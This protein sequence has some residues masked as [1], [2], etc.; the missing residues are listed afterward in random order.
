MILTGIETWKMSNLQNKLLLCFDWSTR[1]IE[2]QQKK[3]SGM[4][5]IKAI[6]LIFQVITATIMTSTGMGCVGCYSPQ[7]FTGTYYLYHQISRRK[8]GADG[9]CEV[10]I[11]KQQTASCLSLKDGNLQIY[12]ENSL[13]QIPSDTD[14]VKPA[15]RH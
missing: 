8:V 7:H 2:R 15:T 9:S 6:L 11:E 14:K 4:T 10:F 3:C 13:V 5:S 12:K 1:F